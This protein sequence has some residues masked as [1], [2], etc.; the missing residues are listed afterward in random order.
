MVNQIISTIAD[1]LG[2]D[3]DESTTVQG[4]TEWTSLKM[5]Q[6]IMALEE[7]DIVIP[8]ERVSAIHSI[9]DIIDFAEKSHD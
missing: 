8:L 3:V 7:C 1:I 5:L 6:I 4:C 2:K 9:K